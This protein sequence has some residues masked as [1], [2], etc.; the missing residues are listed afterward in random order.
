MK[1]LLLL[2]H[3]KASRTSPTGQDIDRPL[4]EEGRADAPLVGQRLRREQLTPDAIICSSAVR[5]QQTIAL[6]IEAAHLTTRPRIEPRIFEASAG[7][8]LEVVSEVEAGAQ[9]LLVVGHIPGLEQ[10]IERLT[11]ASVS[12]SPATL[13]RIDLD[14]KE[15]GEAFTAAGRLAFA[16]P[17]E[18]SEDN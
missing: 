10:L 15:W 6:V 18:A 16:L 14:I 3:A 1:T 2:R 12:M 17:P 4:V 9:T 13:A 7:R 8:L 5:A 11:G